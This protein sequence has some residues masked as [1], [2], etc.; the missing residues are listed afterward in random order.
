MGCKHL[1]RIVIMEFSD[2]YNFDATNIKR[3]CNF[4]IEL[5]RATPFSAYNMGIG[6]SQ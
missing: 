5:G 4:M 6:F 3:E 1:F 2:I